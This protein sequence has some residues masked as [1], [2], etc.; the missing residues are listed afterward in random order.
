M[1]I[2]IT[3]KHHLTPVIMKAKVAQLCT[4]LRPRGLYPAGLLCSWDCPGKSIGVGLDPGIEP[5]SPAS[6]ANSLLFG[7]SGKPT[8][9]NGYHQKDNK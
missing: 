2:K 6:Q 5:G 4:T 1:Q 8:C 7:P 3:V 9:H